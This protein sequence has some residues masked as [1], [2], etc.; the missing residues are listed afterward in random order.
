[1]GHH[2]INDTDPLARSRQRG[3]ATAAQIDRA[4]LD[5]RALELRHQG[6]TYDEVAVALEMSNKS[7][8]RESVGC[9][10]A[11]F[12]GVIMSRGVL[13]RRSCLGW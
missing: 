6:A 11:G 8:L 5:R 12:G 4:A 10:S 3:K 7:A 1:M 2:K 13:G 9:E